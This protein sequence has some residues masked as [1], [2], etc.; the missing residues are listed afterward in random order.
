MY[1]SLDISTSGMVAQRTRLAAIAA[2]IAN[3][4]T[5]LDANGQN[6]PFKRRIAHFS[7]GDPSADSRSGRR[8]GVH[9]STIE[10]DESAVRKRYSPGNKFADKDGYILVPD[11]STSTEQLDALT[12]TRA[13]EANV[14]AAEVTK[15]MVAQALRLLA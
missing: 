10:A 8:F 3:S 15:G 13:Y 4:G 1:G 6:V 2:N 5:I 11:I 7:P 14:A 9:V 12:A